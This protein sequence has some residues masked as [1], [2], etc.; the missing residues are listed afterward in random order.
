MRLSEL[1]GTTVVDQGGRRIGTATDVRLVQDGPLS[2]EYTASLRLA[3]I[4]VVERRH[5]RLLG[6][7]RDVGPWIIRLLVRRLCGHVTRVA[8]DHVES[9]T[10]TQIV[11]RSG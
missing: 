2:S 8:W 10:P 4:V 6:Y 3:E 7:E 1:L 5:V 11:I 9:I